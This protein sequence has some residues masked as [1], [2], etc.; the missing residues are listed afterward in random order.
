MGFNFPNSPTPGQVFTPVGGYQYVWLDGVWRVVESPQDVVTAQTRNRV[1][2]PAMQISQQLALGGTAVLSGA[3]PHIYGADQWVAQNVTASTT[4]SISTRNDVV[5]P[6]VIGGCVTLSGPRPTHR[7]RRVTWLAC[8]SQSRASGWLIS[9]GARRAPGK[10]FCDSRRVRAWPALSVSRCETATIR[11][12]GSRIARLRHR[13][14]Q[15]FVLV[16]PGDMT[17]TWPKDTYGRDD[18]LL[19]LHGGDLFHGVEG[20]Q[21]GNFN[22]TAACSNWLGTANALSS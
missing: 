7:L 19:D 8:S 1:C 9:H 13:L 10:R 17:G 4:T 12:H 14:D 5:N 20:W 15:E 3:G 18:R 21:A 16:I 2:N 11:G 22:A 6:D